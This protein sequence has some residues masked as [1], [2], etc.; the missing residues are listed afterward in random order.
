[1]AARPT[2]GKAGASPLRLL[3]PSVCRESRTTWDAGETRVQKLP[4]SVLRDGQK[5]CSQ[6]SWLAQD[7]ACSQPD[8]LFWGEWGRGGDRVGTVWMGWEQ[9]GDGVGGALHCG[10][11]SQ[12]TWDPPASMATTA[13][14]SWPWSCRGPGGDND[15]TG[16]PSTK[17]RLEPQGRW[18]T[19]CRNEHGA[20]SG[21]RHHHAPNRANFLSP[22]PAVCPVVKPE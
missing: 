18:K 14:E 1:M 7:A 11:V 2:A 4:G 21:P 15:L 6:R 22:T 12:E 13:C 20:K 17:H 19:R 5:T 10:Q 8:A 3:C 16:H 9:T